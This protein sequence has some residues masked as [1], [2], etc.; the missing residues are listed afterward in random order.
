MLQSESGAAILSFPAFITMFSFGHMVAHHLMWV[1]SLISP[2]A[3][4]SGS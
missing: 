1:R 3:C 4:A 2:L